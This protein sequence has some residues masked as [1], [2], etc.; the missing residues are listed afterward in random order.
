MCGP[1]IFFYC[2]LSGAKSRD[3]Q[4][5]QRF[6]PHPYPCGGISDVEATPN[7]RPIGSYIISSSAKANLARTNLLEIICLICAQVWCKYCNQSTL[8]Y[9]TWT[10]FQ[11]CSS[12]S[13]WVILHVTGR[14]Q[15]V[16]PRVKSVT[17]WVRQGGGQYLKGAG[18]GQAETRG[19][20]GGAIC[21]V[22]PGVIDG[23]YR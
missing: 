23:S 19:A 22:I 14:K 15:A 11:R 16:D 4:Y 7:P 2:V 13:R 21:R 17:L 20:S 5:S 6:C 10:L 9:H 3:G 1:G 12:H 8:L 18:D